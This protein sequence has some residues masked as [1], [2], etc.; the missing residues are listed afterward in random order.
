M[1]VVKLGGSLFRSDHLPS[2]LKLLAESDSLVVV[3]GGGP[4]ADQVREAQ[5]TWQF[6]DSSAHAMALLAMEQ[7]GH[8]LCAMQSGLVAA[9]TP[10]QIND[11]LKQ[12]KIPVWMPCSMVLSDH[13]INQSW[14]VTSDSLAAWLCGELRAENLLLVKSVRPEKGATSMEVLTR[15]G[16]VDSQLGRF[17]QAQSTKAWL[18]HANDHQYLAG[19]EQDQE[20]NGRG[21]LPITQ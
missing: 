12:G 6:D 11:A 15:A 13:R 1:W 14:E 2:W 3:P 21:M 16:I 5:A 4:F 7:F 8:I 9:S 10:T 20:I 19:F 17:L 18:T